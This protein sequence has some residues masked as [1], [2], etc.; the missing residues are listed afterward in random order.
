MNNSIEKKI[1]NKRQIGS[2]YE[3]KAVE[4]LKEQGQIILEVNYRNILGEIDII[5]RDKEC[6]CFIE[7]KYRMNNHFG[8]PFEAVDIHKQKQIKK[9]AKY[10]LMQHGFNE[11][12]PCRFDVIGFEGENLTYLQNAF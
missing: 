10:Y 9:V 4:F 12:I 3:Q 2:V 11:W 6:L 7:V 8:S 1:Q 5:T